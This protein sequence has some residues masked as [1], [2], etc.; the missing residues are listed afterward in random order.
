MTM[1]LEHIN[2]TVRNVEESVR[3]YCTLLGG[4]VSWRGTATNM[5][6]VVPAA[7]VRMGDDYISMFERE[8]G[9][10]AIHDYGPPGINHVGFVIDDLSE[11]RARLAELETEIVMEADYAPGYRLYAFDPNGIELELVH[12]GTDSE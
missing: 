2:M 7:H 9:E 10:R 11:T 12:Y 1:Y 4:E 6:K 3:F 5:N 8:S